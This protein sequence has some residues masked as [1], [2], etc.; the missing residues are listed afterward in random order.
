M[1]SVNKMDYLPLERYPT[2]ASVKGT[3][4]QMEKGLINDC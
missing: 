4:M 2:V 3:I 1:I